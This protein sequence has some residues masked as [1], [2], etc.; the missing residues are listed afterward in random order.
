MTEKELTL[1][2]IEKFSQYVR[3]KKTSLQLTNKELGEKV[4]VSEGE[5]SKIINKKR[6]SV[7]LHSFYNITIN[8]GDTIELAKDLIYPHRSFELNKIDSEIDIN[9]TR[10]GFGK[11]MQDNFETD[12]LNN[13]QGE[14]SFEIILAKTGI[15]ETRLKTIYFGTGAPEPYEFL[16]IEKAVGEKCGEM[17]KDYVDKHPIKKTKKKE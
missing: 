2:D 7:S 3:S 1:L 11:Y 12:T 15:K 9:R 17:M 10:K 6:L 5:I 16:L 14:N 13:V 8:T 4:G